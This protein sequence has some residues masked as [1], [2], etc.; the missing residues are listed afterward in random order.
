MSRTTTGTAM[1][2]LLAL[3]LATFAGCGADKEG[4]GA[5]ATT[6][7]TRKAGMVAALLPD[8]KSSVRWESVDRPFLTQAFEKAGVPIQISNAEGDKSAQQQQ[9]E[10][11]ITNGAKVLILVNLDPGS[12]AAIAANAK[13]QGVK[14]IDYDRLTIDGDSD[15]YVSF[16]N[17]RV[18][19]LQG[20]GL[21][22]CLEAKGVS[23]PRI[24]RLNGSPT[25][26]NAAL[27]KAGSDKVLK[28]LFASN[29]AVDVRR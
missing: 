12:G 18:G 21:A 20:E 9:A 29:D 10:Q 6:S 22:S 13:A 17:E 3:T 8:S 28:P 4:T 1:T 27:L 26:N 7:A 24:A 15:Y 14:V 19:E 11:A 2:A 23:N 25:D 5:T 16:D